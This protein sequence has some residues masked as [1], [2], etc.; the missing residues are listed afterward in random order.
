MPG[1]MANAAPLKIAE[2]ILSPPRL[3]AEKAHHLSGGIWS[4]YIV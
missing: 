4:P 3:L 1:S 2:V